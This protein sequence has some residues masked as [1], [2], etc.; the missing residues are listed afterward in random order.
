MAATALDPTVR[1]SVPVRLAWLGVRA[2]LVIAA[3]IAAD[4]GF[5]KYSY[6]APEGQRPPGPWQPLWHLW[7]ASIALTVAAGFL[8]TLA[9]RLPLRVSI[10]TH[11]LVLAAVL[12][13]LLVH[14]WWLFH[15]F[16]ASGL[17][18][19]YYWF[20]GRA[21]QAVCAVLFGVALA[22]IPNRRHPPL[23]SKP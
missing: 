6:F 3:W 23:R 15:P 9:V 7:A 1:S 13:P 4:A 17:F 11:P 22:S 21:G 19:N 18:R 10:R 2:T 16:R 12:I 20:D 8:F 14:L 5:W